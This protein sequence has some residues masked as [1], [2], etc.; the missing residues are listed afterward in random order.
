MENRF[1]MNIL[2]NVFNM[3]VKDVHMLLLKCPPI[4]PCLERI[5]FEAIKKCDI[6]DF[7]ISCFGFFK[8]TYEKVMP[9]LKYETFLSNMEYLLD[10]RNKYDRLE[11]V[12]LTMLDIPEL[13]GGEWEQAKSFVKTIV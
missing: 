1:W 7:R 12:S 4:C 10:F 5:F 3:S 8:E 11:N 9:G 2:G 13:K 6:D